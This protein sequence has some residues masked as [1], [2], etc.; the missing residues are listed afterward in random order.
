MFIWLLRKYD[1]MAIDL[2][3]LRLSPPSRAV[4]MLTKHLDIKVNIKNMD[5]RNGEHL[6]SDYAKVCLKQNDISI[7]WIVCSGKPDPK[8]SSSL[9][10]SEVKK[11]AV[12][13]QLLNFD[14]FYYQSLREALVTN[15]SL[16]LL[17][18]SKIGLFLIDQ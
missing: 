18:Y 6:T 14:M 17:K 5:L 11:R 7:T 10:P 12:V 9:Y 16:F 2:Y 3:F 1:K 4:L 13:D 8:S 15:S